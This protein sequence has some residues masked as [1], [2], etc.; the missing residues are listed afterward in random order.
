MQSMVCGC[1]GSA[2]TC[3]NLCSIVNWERHKVN[4]KG[5]PQVIHVDSVGVRSGF[6]AVCLAGKSE[7]SASKPLMRASNLK[8]LNG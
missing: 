1:Q 4:E 5:L 6:D 8:G 2:L 7:R 3:I